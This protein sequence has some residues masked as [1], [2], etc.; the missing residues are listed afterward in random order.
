[1]L[2]DSVILRWWALTQDCERSRQAAKDSALGD[3]AVTTGTVAA[4][5]YRLNFE[6][7]PFADRG[8]KPLRPT[9][10]ARSNRL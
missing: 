9:E 5:V 4:P 8:C 10:Q 7:A 1:M 2:I 3:G 6:G